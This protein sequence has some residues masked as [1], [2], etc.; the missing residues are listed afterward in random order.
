[1]LSEDG[2]DT[3][4][5]AKERLMNSAAFN[6]FSMNRYLLVI[7]GCD[8]ALD[9][10]EFSGSEGL[11]SLYRYRVRFTCPQADIPMAQVLRKSAWLTLRALPQET[12]VPLPETLRTVH[13]VV[14]GFQR[15]AGSPDQTCYEIILEPFLALLSRQTRSHRFF[16]GKTVPKVVEEVL[17]EHGLKGWE[18]EFHLKESYSP[19]EQIHQYRESDLAF[20]ERLLAEVGIHYF[21][22]LQPETLTEIVHFADCQ[23]AWLYDKTLRLNSPSGMEDG[24]ATAVWALTVSHSVAAASVTTGDYNPRQAHLRLE[25]A[26]ADVSGGDDEAVTYGDEWLYGTGHH[27][28]G[29]ALWPA[30]ETGNFYARLAHE[31]QLC[32]RTEVTGESS[33]AT[34]GPAQVINVKADAVSP[35]PEALSGWLLVV[36]VTL[37][38]SRR[39]ALKVAFSAVP[40]RSP[41]VWRPMLKPRPVVSGTLMARVTS[42]RSGDLYAWQDAAGLYRVR[43][44][45]DRDERTAGQES[46][47]VRLAKPY[48]GDMYGFHFPLIQGTEVAIAFHNGD[49]D[50][51]YIAHALHDSRHP[52]HVTE[53]NST[54]NV[55]RTPANNKLRMEDK[56]GEEHIK[57][58]TEHGKT[59]LNLGHNVNAERQLRGEGAE[60]RTD[61]HVALRGGKGVF[62]SAEAQPKADGEMLAMAEAAERLTAAGEQLKAL[63]DDAQTAKA[64]PAQ[65]EAQLAFMREKIERLQKAVALLSAPEGIALTSGKHLQLAAS[66]NVMVNA[67]AD[68]D[69]GVIKR[70]FIGVGEGVSLFVRRLGMKLIANQGE[71]TIQAQNDQMQLLARHGLEIVSTEDEIHIM[72]KKKITLNAGG[73]YITLDPYR[74]EQGTQGDFAVKAVDFDYSGPASMQA[75]HPDYPP[76]QATAVQSLR[77]SLPQAANATD[78]ASWVGMPYTL[79]ANGA[80]LSQGVLDANGQ[81]EIDHQIATRDY[82]LVMANGAS[83]EI[84]VVSEFRNPDQGILA[85]LGLHN[86]APQPDEEVVSPADHT[87]HRH[88]YVDMLQGS[89]NREENQ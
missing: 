38:A 74:I 24:G 42:A 2:I 35:L 57:L 7:E 15:L 13:G 65:W 61:G 9:V 30:A 86:H 77:F 50:R 4:S 34:L 43:F 14:T 27:E 46:M 40:D 63:S 67:G 62:I 21:F 54:R 81:L 25:S 37:S 73:S 75:E 31:R 83:Y 59:Q 87:H 45:A 44:D 82:R 68:A 23:E 52:D 47:P 60:L 64:E 72:A 56:R 3:A 78:N 32:R 33:D 20:I 89:T 18:F 36:S 84:P 28:R 88:L 76:L 10:E 69:I 79:Y 66:R 8:A 19:R 1:L 70:L 26:A 6:Y 17:R 12:T 55:I 58:A 85:N 16:L 51:P 41:Q 5:V 29:E 71:V 11:S 80:P 39:Q 48:G 53:K 49:P 22:T